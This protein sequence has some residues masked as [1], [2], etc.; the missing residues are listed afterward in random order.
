MHGRQ[1]LAFPSGPAAKILP[2]NP[3]YRRSGDLDLN[4]AIRILNSTASNML[5]GVIHSNHDKVRC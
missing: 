4:E 5:E 3:A 2:M 1:L